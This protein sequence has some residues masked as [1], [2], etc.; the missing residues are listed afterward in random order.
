MLKEGNIN[1]SA[2]SRVDDINI[3][4]FN[5]SFSGDQSGSYTVSKNI[6]NSSLYA[7][8]QET[9]ELDYEEFEK[10]AMEFSEQ[11]KEGW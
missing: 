11:I 4:Y 7:E 3:A 5:A 6:V 9:C 8:N 2:T 10:K 1:I